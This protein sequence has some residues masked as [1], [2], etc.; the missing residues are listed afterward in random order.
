MR[1]LELGPLNGGNWI[2]CNWISGNP[3][4]ERVFGKT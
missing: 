2:G 1:R 4:G 3:E